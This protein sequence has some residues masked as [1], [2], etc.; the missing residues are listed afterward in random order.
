MWGQVGC[1]CCGETLIES[2]PELRELL[3]TAWR[4]GSQIRGLGMATHPA[5]YRLPGSSTQSHRLCQECVTACACDAARTPMCP[6]YQLTLG[7]GI[8]EPGRMSLF[9]EES[10]VCRALKRVP[11][12]PPP[13]PPRTG[14]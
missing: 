9:F 5:W 8:L 11:M 7:P 3:R 1:I 12:C 14:W 10:G 13:P 4:Q 2:Q 6:M